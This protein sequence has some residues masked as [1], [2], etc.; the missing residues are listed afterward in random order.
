MH[1]YEKTMESCKRQERTILDSTLGRKKEMQ[2]NSWQRGIGE[3]DNDV[4][5]LTFEKYFTT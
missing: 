4:Y 5:T 1:D 3:V 2:G